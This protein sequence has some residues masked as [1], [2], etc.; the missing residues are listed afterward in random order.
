MHH[1]FKFLMLKHKC[2]PFTLH[3]TLGH[4]HFE[5]QFVECVHCSTST[6]QADGAEEACF[7]VVHFQGQKLASKSK[8]QVCERSEAS[9]VHLRPIQSQTI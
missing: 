5:T 8:H 9:V 2:C 6:D 3:L 7:C 1:Y 4:L